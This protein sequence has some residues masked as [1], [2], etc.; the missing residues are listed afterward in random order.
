LDKVE[1]GLLRG[2]ENLMMPVRQ[3]RY[4][5]ITLPQS[6]YFDSS[7]NYGFNEEPIISF[8]FN[9]DDPESS[10]NGS[11]SNNIILDQLN[12]TVNMINNVT[13][14]VDYGYPYN[15]SGQRSL[16]SVERGRVGNSNNNSFNPRS[17]LVSLNDT[18]KRR[19]KWDNLND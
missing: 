6:N 8:H 18:R 9:Q 7:G 12:T 15:F 3:A 4:D 5:A 1:S 10:N 13:A 2:D 11:S 19:R 16:T 17:S 14:D